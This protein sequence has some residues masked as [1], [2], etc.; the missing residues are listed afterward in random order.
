MY[1]VKKNLLISNRPILCC[2]EVQN[3]E[4]E[5]MMKDNPVKFYPSLLFPGKVVQ[6]L[7]TRNVS[8]RVTDQG[9]LGRGGGGRTETLF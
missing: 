5:K 8:V 9:R 1:F 7:I 6:Q 2:A 3:D 4:Y